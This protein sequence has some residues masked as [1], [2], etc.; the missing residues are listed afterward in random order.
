LTRYRLQRLAEHTVAP[1][2]RKA[3]F[4]ML[5]VRTAMPGIA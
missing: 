5:F 4:T 3:G 1:E 2:R